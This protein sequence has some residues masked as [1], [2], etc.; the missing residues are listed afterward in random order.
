MTSTVKAHSRK[1]KGGKR[2]CVLVSAYVRLTAKTLKKDSGY[3]CGKYGTMS[4]GQI[5]S[6][7]CLAKDD[8]NQCP[9]LVRIQGTPD[10][11]YLLKK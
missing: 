8:Q 9:R 10:L 4:L 1:K 6:H 5:I 2:K 11:I 3:F 7:S